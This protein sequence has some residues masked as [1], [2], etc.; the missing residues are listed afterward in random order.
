[1]ITQGDPAIEIPAVPLRTD[2]RDLLWCPFVPAISPDAAQARAHTLA[3]LT[4]AGIITSAPQRAYVD[5]MR[6]DL[7][8]A[9][10]A[11][12]L[13]GPQLDLFCDW[14]VFTTQLDDHLDSND[15]AAIHPLVRQLV[16]VLDHDDPDRASAAEDPFVTAFGELWR[17]CGHIPQPWRRQLADGWAQWI[18]AYLTEAGWRQARLW[19]S[20]AR[21]RYT[22]RTTSAALPF[23]LLSELLSGIWL[24]DR[25][26]NSAAL[27]ALRVVVPD[28]TMAVNDV[29][30]APREALTGDHLNAVFITERE[31]RCTRDQAVAMTID[32]AN[33]AIRHFLRLVDA[34]PR[35]CDDLRLTAAERESVRRWVSGLQH[36]LRG[37]LD[38]HTTDTHRYATGIRPLGGTQA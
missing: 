18:E 8:A 4:R 21:Y 19:P 17:Q 37:N 15:P 13:R 2:V 36:W 38:W 25:V 6:L 16:G 35:T 10:V 32:Y 30:G 12:A 33:A 5:A 26:L 27:N 9:R 23:T 29:F 11:P 7:Y 1:M 34:L 31:Y 22:V 3:W 28:H 14:I 24:P 20:L